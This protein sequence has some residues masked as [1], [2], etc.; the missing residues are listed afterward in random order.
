MKPLIHK[1]LLLFLVN[2][3]LSAATISVPQDVATIQAAIDQAASGDTILVGQGTY[4]ENLTCSGKNLTLDGSA[5][6]HAP[7]IAGGGNG[8]VLTADQNAAI[9]LK[10]LVI[11]DGNYT[12]YGA[13]ILIEGAQV[14]LMQCTLQ[15]NN[16]TLRGGAMMVRTGGQA[17]LEDTTIAGNSAFFFGG[18]ICADTGSQVIMTRC[19]IVDNTVSM[20]GAAF[21]VD[22]DSEISINN[23]LISGNRTSQNSMGTVAT[24]NGGICKLVNVTCAG[25]G[26]G[27]GHAFALSAGSR[28]ELINTILWNGGEEIAAPAGSEVLA[29]YSTIQ[30]TIVT[31]EGVI[32]AD[33]LFIAP[34]DNDFQL[35]AGSPCIDFSDAAEAP[36]TDMAGNDRWDDPTVPNSG[37]LET[38]F[39]DMGALEYLPPPGPIQNLTCRVVNR[40]SRLF[41]EN[42]G[43]YDSIEIRRNG[44]LAVTLPGDAEFWEDEVPPTGSVVYHLLGQYGFESTPEVDCQLTVPPRAVTGL[45]CTADGEA[46][47]LTWQNPESFEL[48]AVW[49]DGALLAE[50]AGI[51]TGYTDPD[52]ALQDHDYQVVSKVQDLESAA[53]SCHYHVFIPPPEGISGLKC[54][55]NGTDIGLSWSNNSVYDAIVITLNDAVLET[56]A[57]SEVQYNDVIDNL[58]GVITYQV[59]AV[60]DEAMVGNPLACSIEIALAPPVDV[61]CAAED[62]DVTVTWTNQAGYDQVE[63]YRDGVLSQSLAGDARSAVV[64]ALDP[65]AYLFTVVGLVGDVVSQPAGCNVT[66]IVAP[67]ASPE[68]LACN[69]S[70]LAVQVTWTAGDEYDRIEVYRNDVHLQELAGDAL[71]LT[72]N[73]PEAG[74]YAYA[75]V[76]YQ[77][78][79]S[80]P[81]V[82]CTVTASVILPA[83]PTNVSCTAQG[84]QVLLQWDM[85]D[86]EAAV[87]IWRNETWLADMTP[88]ET[89]FEDFADDAGTFTYALS[90]LKD[91][92]MSEAVPCTAMTT[93]PEAT[94]TGASDGE[95]RQ[96]ELPADHV[97]LF[98]LLLSAPPEEGIVFSA[99]RLE[100]TGDADPNELHNIRLMV[101][102]NRDGICQPDS[103]THVADGVMSDGFL[104]ATGFALTL[105]AAE[106]AVVLVVA[107]IREETDKSAQAGILSNVGHS[108]MSPPLPG[109]TGLFL[110]AAVLACLLMTF[111]RMIRSRRCIIHAACLFMLLIFAGC[112]EN[113]S[114]RPKSDPIT[115]GQ[116]RTAYQFMLASESDIT[117]HGARS[118][119]PCDVQG[120]P[121]Q[122]PAVDIIR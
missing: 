19:R 66:V 64:E 16:A 46:V 101:D 122:G 39:A 81:P 36:E 87:R 8:S 104:T 41:W 23:S 70:D 40:K 89:F 57:G 86:P 27:Q 95:S 88:G 109:G 120:A 111:P 24:I 4:S 18:A 50:L 12:D 84:L 98:S 114:G 71:S 85:A 77:G 21:R 69:E 33:P 107:D 99:L 75:L 67:L 42:T 47:S 68:N 25:N 13:G 5:N 31:G 65:G 52:A 20:L 100:A 121:L 11:Q 105:A 93:L 82:S 91:D 51:S 112:S 103:D 28:L 26:L 2:L 119:L 79:R 10:N 58:V 32:D 72:D 56:L 53:A 62:Q 61:T 34:Q 15:H 1:L 115:P 90:A 49:R 9:T 3:P 63:L 35:N 44:I 48:I 60:I 94:I 6:D 17:T 118:G 37:T 54:T 108:R 73:A 92:R 80:A 106:D 14:T 38:A 96:V 117:V 113:S 102:E 116:P 97:V 110:L 43:V 29:R 78:D 59:H 83:P 55:K 7:I 30:N 76:A 22:P 74:E 45:S